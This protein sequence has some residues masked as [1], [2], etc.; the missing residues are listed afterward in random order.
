LAKRDVATTAL[1]VAA[2]RARE[3]A[4]DDPLFRDELSSLLAGTEGLA[5]LKSAEADPRSNYRV[6]SFPYLEVR[7]R[8]FDDWVLNAARNAG[9]LVLLGAGMD[10]RAFRLPWP[11]EFRLWEV[12][13]ADLFA[14]KEPRLQ[15]AGARPACKRVVVEADLTS[16]GWVRQL[17]EKGFERSRPSIWLAEGLFQYLS[18][19]DVDQILEGA[20]GVSSPGSQFGAEIISAEYL[21]RASNLPLLRRRAARGTPW[22]FGTDEP[23]ALFLRHHWLVDE[24]VGALDAAIALGRWSVRRSRDSTPGATFVSASKLGLGRVAA[25]RR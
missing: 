5:W 23:D 10:T 21:R 12:D 17:L 7:T 25:R 24:R 1:F 3:N 22:R 9:Q 6:G 13:T 15:S 4:R 19:A 18:G 16:P 14:L 2:V 8:Y 11:E 20:A